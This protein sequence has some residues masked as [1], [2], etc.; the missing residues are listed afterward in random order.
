MNWI[1]LLI[2]L[3]VFIIIWQK[4]LKRKQQL[5]YIETYF[6]HKGIRNKISLK[7]P[8]LSDQQLDLVFDALKD[9]FQICLIANKKWSPCHLKLL[10]MPGMNLSYQ[11]VFIL[12]FVK[13]H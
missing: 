2:V 7:H 13:K 5:K 3:F 4:K 6:F 9:Y 12:F 8:Q 11:L 10:M 1:M